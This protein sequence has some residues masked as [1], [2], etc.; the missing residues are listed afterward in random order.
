MCLIGEVEVAKRLTSSKVDLIIFTGSTDKGKLVARAA[1][2]NLTPCVLELGGKCPTVV[3]LQA[4]IEF[5]A[6][7]VATMAFANS[8]QLCV[9]PDYCLVN[10]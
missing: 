9:R 6:K 10:Y 5:A 8:G 3:D 1:A 4:D 7:K 2:E